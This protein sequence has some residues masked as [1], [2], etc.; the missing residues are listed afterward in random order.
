MT[1]GTTTKRKNKTKKQKS[2]WVKTLLLIFLSL[3]LIATAIG[4]NQLYRMSYRN[5]CTKS[6]QVEYLY[7]NS[8]LSI[9]EL[10]A[11]MEDNYVIESKWNFKLHA[12]MLKF[13]YVMPGRYLVNPIE[14]DLNFIRRLR[15]GEQTPVKISFNNIRTKAQLSQK[16]AEQLMTDSATIHMLLNNKEFLK[17]YNVTPE[18]ALT[19]FLPNTYEVYWSTS[20]KALINRLYREYTAFWNKERIEK[21]QK[22][23]LTP[24]EVSVLASIVEE[25]TNKAKEKPIVAGLYLNR[26]RIGMPLQADPTVKFAVG[27]FTLRRILYKHLAIDSPYNTYKYKGLPPGPIRIPSINGLEA[28]LNRTQHN[29]LYMCA[30]ETFNGEHN[31]ASTLAEHNRNAQRYQAA[32]NKR[33]I[34]K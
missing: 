13:N 14:A 10:I 27:D 9:D 34:M 5:I 23:G 8:R 20:A 19:L 6:Q 31:F 4:I 17:E 28:V 18:T 2:N 15:N 33:K 1:K 22:I 3:F 25:E 26:L 29:Y 12:E 16:L 30:K 21:A 11:F 24:T 32:L 7:I